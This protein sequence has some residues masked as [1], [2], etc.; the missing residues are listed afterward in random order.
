MDFVKI[1]LTNGNSPIVP[2]T[3][4]ET[5]RRIF[6]NQISEIIYPDIDGNFKETP[7]ADNNPLKKAVEMYQVENAELEKENAELKEALAKKKPGRKKAIA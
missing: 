7:K 1:I 2:T 4:L 5:F 6:W 3:N